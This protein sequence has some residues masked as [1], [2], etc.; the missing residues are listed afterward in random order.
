MTIKVG[1]LLYVSTALRG[2]KAAKIMGETKASWLMPDGGK[3]SKKTMLQSRRRN[4]PLRWFDK[5][6]KLDHD[7]CERWARD[8]AGSVAVCKDAEKLVQIAAMVGFDLK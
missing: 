2:W 6:G 4:T 3:V 1:D 5:A 8:I 7:F